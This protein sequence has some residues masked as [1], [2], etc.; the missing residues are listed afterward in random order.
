MKMNKLQQ[1][2]ATRMNL[3]NYNSEYKKP[4]NKKY[5]NNKEKTIHT[6]LKYF[7]K[8]SP[9]GRHL[10]VVQ[11]CSVTLGASVSSALKWRQS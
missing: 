1:H 2:V 10:L 5:Q 6:I 4:E 8:W 3:T 7:S 9:E 11:L